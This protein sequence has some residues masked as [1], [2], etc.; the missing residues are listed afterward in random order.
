M[1]NKINIFEKEYDGESLYDLDRDISEAF[2]LE[3][4]KIIDTIPTD[5]YGIHTGKFNVKITWESE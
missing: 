3:F 1:S 4:N 5:Q 2:I